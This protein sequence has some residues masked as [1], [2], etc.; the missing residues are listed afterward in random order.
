M[1][2]DDQTSLSRWIRTLPR[3][4]GREV[5]LALSFATHVRK[6]V[7]DVTLSRVDRLASLYRI[8]QDLDAMAA[9]DRPAL[10]VCQ[11]LASV[12]TARG[13]PLEPLRHLLA[14]ARD[15]LTTDRYGNF[16]EL[17]VHVRRAANPIGRLALHLC[18]AASPRSVALSDGLCCGLWLTAMLRDVPHDFARGRLYLPL[19]DLERHRVTEA[20]ITAHQAT[21]GWRA[22]IMFEV[23]R[24]RRMLQAGAP[25]GRV[26]GGRAGFA[27]RVLVL[28]AE[29]ILKKLHEAPGDVFTCRPEVTKGDWPYLIGRALVPRYRP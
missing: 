1:P 2:A 13:L 25:L 10:Q 3:Q 23:E 21:G 12:V 28:A 5:G 6:V 19:E 17:M 24:T 20:Q 29:R 9:G 26:L 8:E 14:A 16:G 7:D 27:T 15:D 4:L 22:L 18:D 11:A